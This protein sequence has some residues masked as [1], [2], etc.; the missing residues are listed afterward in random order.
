LLEATRIAEGTTARSSAHLTV[1]S[2][3]DPDQLQRRV[4]DAGAEAAIRA[5]RFGIERV[6]ALDAEAGGRARFRRVSG[7]LWARDERELAHVVEVAS[8][9]ER[10]GERATAPAAIRIGDHRFRGMELHD[11]AMIDPVTYLHGLL[12]L[13]LA[14]GVVVHEQ[15]EVVDWEGGATVSATTRH[16]RV[17]G[18][19]LVLATHTPIG[20]VG[21]LQ[22]RLSPC[23]S[24]LVAG[25]PSRA[26]PTGLYWDLDEPYHYVRTLDDGRVLIGGEDLAPGTGDGRT[27]VSRLVEWGR[28]W[29]GLGQVDAAWSDLW[30]ESA[31]GLPY[32]G[33]LPLHPHVW[34]GTGYSGTGLTW[35]TFAGERIAAAILGEPRPDDE[36]FAP[37]R[38]SMVG[39]A[40]RMVHAQLDVGWH[41]VV[42]RL[43][44]A[45]DLR[46]QDLSPGEGRILA[47]DGHKVG[48]FR[49]DDGKLYAV[50]PVCRHLGCLVGWNA[51]DR[52]WDC[53]CHGGR[54]RADG[55]RFYG[56][57]M[58]DLIRVDL[59]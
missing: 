3:T 13:A 2:D 23:M 29:L 53:P 42:D 48:V 43:R 16:G 59:D 28:H 14:A 25:T 33:R 35:G 45:G 51:L 36:H 46:P 57:P 18:S 39:S 15:S 26:L 12:R 17:R 55:T 34:V 52:T 47:I 1:E 54:Y 27:A 44:P 4:G 40:D 50:S 49:D 9:Y 37:S 20:L 41:M 19:E 11:Q 8:V 38:L 6:A 56:P 32:V 21:T 31:D 58:K 5:G 30:F 24:Y 7:W 22:T 10:F